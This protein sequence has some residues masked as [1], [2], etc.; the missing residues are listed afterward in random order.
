MTQDDRF[1][2]YNRIYLLVG[3]PAQLNASIKGLDLSA[4]I[5]ARDQYDKLVEKLFKIAEKYGEKAL[6]FTLIQDGSFCSGVTVNGKKFRWT[7]NCGLSM[8]SRY[9]GDLWIDGIGTVF[10]SGSVAKVYEYLLN[11]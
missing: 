3:T 8:R 1:A 9:C 7:P 5:K 11:N 6:M 4:R 2:I 10:T